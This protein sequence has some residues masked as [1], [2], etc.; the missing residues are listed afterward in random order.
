MPHNIPQISSPSPTAPERTRRAS[1]CCPGSA[2]N[3]EECLTGYDAQQA[4]SVEACDGGTTAVTCHWSIQVAPE[5]QSRVPTGPSVSYM[6]YCQPPTLQLQNSTPP[7]LAGVDA[8]CSTQP[9]RPTAAHLPV[10]Q[11][12]IQQ[13]TLQCNSM[14]DVNIEAYHTF[15]EFASF[16]G[17]NAFA[18]WD[19]SN[20]RQPSQLGPPTCQAAHVV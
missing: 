20:I 9:G 18:L 10:R 3:P 16:P 15:V 2:Q 7:S 11:A 17:M 19:S 13:N 1:S 6:P 4:Q 5:R 12:R 8:V 14:Q